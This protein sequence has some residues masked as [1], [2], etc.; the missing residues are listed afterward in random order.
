VSDGVITRDEDGRLVEH[1]PIWLYW[2]GPHNAD[3]DVWRCR[4]HLEWQGEDIPEDV[5]PVW[6]LRDEWRNYPG[7]LRKLWEEESV[8][9]HAPL[10]NL[11]VQAPSDV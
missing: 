6:E 5:I 7:G 11:T 10:H 2:R 3:V 1:E 9:A 4:D 8:Q